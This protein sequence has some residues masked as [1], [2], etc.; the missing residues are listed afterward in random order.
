MISSKEIFEESAGSAA[1]ATEAR[2]WTID[3]KR[4]DGQAVAKSL[5]PHSN[6][7]WQ[8]PCRPCEAASRC[9]LLTIAVAHKLLRFR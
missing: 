3:R 9:C 4:G 7:G 2:L 6:D 5:A 1:L 8:V